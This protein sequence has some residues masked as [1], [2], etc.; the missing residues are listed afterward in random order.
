MARYQVSFYANKNFLSTIG[1]A[2][3]VSSGSTQVQCT[4][5]PLDLCGWE[6]AARGEYVTASFSRFQSKM[7]GLFGF[8]PTN[9]HSGGTNINLYCFSLFLLL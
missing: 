1:T 5:L 6:N 4:F 7:S 9:D 2:A 3:E 8:G